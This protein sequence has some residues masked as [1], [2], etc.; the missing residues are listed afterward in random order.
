MLVK[1][2]GINGRHIFILM[3]AKIP[4][5]EYSMTWEGTDDYENVVDTRAYI[6]TFFIDDRM[7]ADKTIVKL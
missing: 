2:S 5:G 3:N 1:I 6:I 4:K 7:V